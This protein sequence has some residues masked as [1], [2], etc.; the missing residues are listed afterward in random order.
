MAKISINLF[1]VF[2]VYAEFSS[3]EIHAC[4]KVESSTISSFS[5]QLIKLWNILKNFLNLNAR[6]GDHF[7]GLVIGCITVL[8]QYLHSNVSE[9]KTSGFLS[10]FYPLVAIGSKR[11][12]IH[13]QSSNQTL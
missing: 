5:R 3:C 6:I 13:T 2:R 12:G 4:Q 8:K 7:V 11:S 9:V 10:S 1:L